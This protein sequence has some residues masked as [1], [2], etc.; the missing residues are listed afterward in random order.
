[1]DESL[2]SI[3]VR[4][5]QAFAGLNDIPTISLREAVRNEWERFDLWADNIG[6]LHSGHISL[7]Y[8]FR[9]APLL[10]NFSQK[11]LRDIGRYLSISKSIALI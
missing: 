4:V 1:M 11:L 6:L 2:T 5:N 8:R 10:Y 7:D 9:D 3:G